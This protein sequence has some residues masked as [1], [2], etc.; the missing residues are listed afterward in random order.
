MPI[1]DG[2]LPYTNLHE[3]NNDWVVKTVKEVKDKTDEIDTAV[4]EAKEYSENAKTSELNAKESEDNASLSEQQ[5]S[6][7]YNNI[8]SYTENLS[9]RIDEN[10]EDIEIQTQRIDTIISGTTPDANAE[11]LDIRVGAN[12]V[13]YP[14]AGDAVRTQ[15]DILNDDV[16]L[17]K[18]L[19]YKTKNIYS[20][21]G[22]STDYTSGIATGNLVLLWKNESWYNHRV[23][24]FIPKNS[25]I[26]H[27]KLYK[28]T[29]QTANIVL[30]KRN[31]AL[32]SFSII[33]K[34]SITTGDNELNYIAGDDYFVA[35]ESVTANAIAIG[36][37]RS[38]DTGYYI[39]ATSGN[40]GDT[41][42]FSNQGV[43]RGIN[44]DIDIT[45]PLENGVYHNVIPVGTDK[46]FTNPVYAV[47][48]VN[49]ANDSNKN[50]VYDLII[51]SG[52]YDVITLLGGTQWLQSLTSADYMA[53]VL[54]NDY[55]NLY[56]LGD[57]TLS[58]Q[59]SDNVVTPLMSELVS[60]INLKY[61]NIIDNIKFIAR[62]VRYA[63]HDETGSTTDS[64]LHNR[65]RKVTNCTF[66]HLGNLPT[67]WS[68]TLGYGAGFQYGDKFTYKNCIFSSVSWHDNIV[69]SEP[70]YFDIDNCII[71]QTIKFGSVIANN[72]HYVNINNCSIGYSIQNIE[73]VPNS[74]VGNN[75]FISG[76]GNSTVSEK[77]DTI[78]P[79]FAEETYYKQSGNG[80][81][82]PVG[83]AVKH[84]YGSVIPMTD[85]DDPSLFAGITLEE[86][87]VSGFGLVKRKGYVML[88]Q[89]GITRSMFDKISLVNN[90]LTVSNVKP[91]LVVSGITND[92]AEII[93]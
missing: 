17:L 58:A 70:S 47:E 89:F 9:N 39:K 69:A 5:A 33:D 40:I 3:L 73:E 4:S 65:I 85:N 77:Y 19:H 93:I 24:Y 56:G 57:C 72:K 83:T 29:T 51:D 54:P 36:N 14:T 25:I 10:T 22:V 1:F 52:T 90:A 68:S 41:V 31:T 87:P 66:N 37:V 62:N 46:I 8:Q 11:L 71:R 78:M 55:V 16:S 91:I 53:G 43:V 15:I 49:F 82:I 63:C 34:I 59:I 7:I 76:G 32:W 18:P 38:G 30:L 64:R 23:P 12:G 6:V 26:S 88:S 13:T 21:S 84:Q 92:F 75:F 20:S 27:A 42:T 74:G 2:N 48:G 61:N 60:T 86:I 45:L 50:N 81:A 44:I 28:Q 35:V 67:L 80:Q 79:I